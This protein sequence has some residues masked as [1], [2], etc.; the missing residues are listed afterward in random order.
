MQ[1]VTFKLPPDCDFLARLEC[2]SKYIIHISPLMFSRAATIDL[3]LLKATICDAYQRFVGCNEAPKQFGMEL[4]CALDHDKHLVLYP[5]RL[6][7][8]DDSAQLLSRIIRP[9]HPVQAN[10]IDRYIKSSFC[11]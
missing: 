1:R 9:K 11:P 10:T 4:Q 2:G 6:V 8:F 5:V 3:D 7:P